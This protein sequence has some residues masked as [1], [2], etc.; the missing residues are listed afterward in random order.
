M[1]T[2]HPIHPSRR[3]SAAVSSRPRTCRKRPVVLSPPRF[4]ELDEVHEQAA[5]GALADLFAPYLGS[6]EGDRA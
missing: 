4:V 2:N 1:A 6:R 5:L 3:H